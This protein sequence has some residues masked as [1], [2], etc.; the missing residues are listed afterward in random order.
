[1]KL[2]AAFIAFAVGLSFGAPFFGA[3]VMGAVAWAIVHWVRESSSGAPSPVSVQQP[4]RTPEPSTSLDD[5]P[6]LRDYVQK[7]AL[8]VQALEREV[9]SLKGEPL[10]AP[11]IEEPAPPPPA[12]APVPAPVP[13]RPAE[14]LREPPVEDVKPWEAPPPPVAM[15]EPE[16]PAPEG[17]SLISRLL[18]G[19][20]VAKV[21]AIILFFGVGFLLK[22]AYD[23]GIMPPQLRLAGVALAAVALFVLG[24]KLKQSRRL[25]ALILQGVSSGL[26]YLDVFFALKTYGFI[27]PA[28]GFAL[29]TGLGVVTTLVAVRQDARPMA[30]LGLTGAFMAP[31]L[32]A[33]GSGNYVFLFSYYLLLN[34][35]IL[36][37][38]WFKA[39]RALNL[40]GWFFTFAIAALWGARSYRPEMFWTIEPFLLAFFAIY[41]II[42]VLF[43]TRQPPSLKGLVDGTLVFGTPAAMAVMQSHL[44]WDMPYGLAWSAAIGALLYAL[45]GVIARRL[46]NMRLLS[47][48]YLALAVG[49]ATLAI[50]FAFGAY[51]TFALWSIEGAALLWVGLRQ[52]RL[53]HRA[54]ALLI[55]AAGAGYFFLDYGVYARSNAFFNDATLGCAIIV[56]ASLISAA[57]LRRYRNEITPAERGLGEF[58]VA[59]AAAWWTLGSAD[60]IHHG[61]ERGSQAL[62]TMLWFTATAI[63]VEFAG[64]RAGWGALRAASGLQPLALIAAA[65]LQLNAGGHPLADLGWLGWPLGLG[66]MFWILHR[67]R[68]DAFDGAFALRYGAAWLILAVIATWEA[69]WRLHYKHYVACMAIALAGHLAAALRY[70]LREH[71]SERAPLSALAL[72]W[73]MFFWFAAG[74]DWI[75]ASLP[76]DEEVRGA[77]L[78]VAGTALVYE[79]AHAPLGG[80]TAMRWAAQLP[81]VAI[82]VA[83]GLEMLSGAVDHPFDRW[84]SL[85]WPTVWLL[86]L[87]GL[88]R[89]GTAQTADWRHA[90]AMLAPIVLLTWEAAWQLHHAHYFTCLAIALGGY[91]VGALWHRLHKDSEFAWLSTFALLWSLVFWF[92]AGLGWIDERVPDDAAVRATLLFVA[93]SAVLFEI[94]HSPLAWPALR[95]PARLPWLALPAA[96]LLEFGLGYVRHPFSGWLGF[97]WPLAWLVAIFG[98]RREESEAKAVAVGL[99]HAIALY[100]PLLLASWEL[101]WWLAEWQAGQQWHLSAWAVPSI[102][103]LLG[104]TLARES[105]R[106]PMPQ[107]WPFYRDALL[108]PLVAFLLGWAVVANLST[109]GDLRPLTLYLPLL[110]PLDVTMGAAAL[111]VIAWA[112]CLEA[113]ELRATIWKGLA[114]LGFAWLNAIALRSIHYWDGV[115][116]RFDVLGASVLVQ[117]TLSLLW[118]G[119]AL[120]LMVLSRRRM[121]RPLWIA[122]AAL[123]AVVVGK[124]FLVDLSNTG[125]VAR[126]VSFLGV[127]VLLLIIGYLAPVPPGTKEAE[128][129][130]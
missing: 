77:L 55:Q 46:A 1:V 100:V 11:V 16:A 90:V 110:N 126:I 54:F 66:S 91:A 28:L 112:R 74:L 48:T 21:G 93:G 95:W 128:T 80:W 61:I 14:A 23:R 52:K 68:R 25:Y 60:L 33:T 41:L 6:A 63:V 114:I 123:L 22:F 127:G 18:G 36:A 9:T 53:L 73:A 102:V 38:S 30:L 10:A 85:V 89:E 13:A 118:T 105:R 49:L 76:A 86:G 59:W 19:N 99:R 65:V 104:A 7:L 107:H 96:L 42:P 47:E 17:P 67:Q 56:A 34:L 64:A 4:A 26:L 88:R 101:G 115:P 72:L 71:G 98:L 94:T 78:F 44:V 92:A 5:F 108:V 24:W 116:Y 45:L 39:W 87:F 8:R 124:M 82:P 121:E 29:F 15:P 97:A 122:G 69:G 40:T 113:D 81:W 43:A 125:T 27:G 79:L 50:F 62:A 111:A 51:T 2:L 57:L 31:M 120:T 119:A 129:G 12:P 109:P 103:L 106:W 3:L 83:V 20:I 84:S 75:H 70:R 130:G 37:V 32:A 35:F 58:I 117:A